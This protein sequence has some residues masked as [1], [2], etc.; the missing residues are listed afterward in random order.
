MAVDFTDVA[1]KDLENEFV[2]GNGIDEPV[3]MYNT[4]AGDPN[5]AIYYYSSDNL[6]SVVTLVDADGDVIERY[7][8]DPWGEPTITDGTGTPLTESA[9][10]NPYMFTAREVDTLDGGSL[11]LQHNRHRVLHYKLARWMQNDP[12]GTVPE[13]YMNPSNPIGQYKDG[14]N[15]YEYVVSSPIDTV[16][17]MGLSP[18]AIALSQ[19][20]QSVPMALGR[21][22]RVCDKYKCPCGDCLSVAQCKRE[23][24]KLYNS[25]RTKL[26][27][28]IKKRNKDLKEGKLP[29]AEK[30]WPWGRCY[31]FCHDY[32]G[33]I[34]S[35]NLGA[36]LKCFKFERAID[37][38]N[39]SGHHYVGVFHICNRSVDTDEPCSDANLDPW[40][41][42]DFF[43]TA[44][45]KSGTCLP[46][47]YWGFEKG[48]GEAFQ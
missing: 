28:F 45:V 15:V 34:S 40:K 9:V 33:E 42:G 43:P 18:T 44:T 29:N 20:G 47:M 35:W 48:I 32:A 27:D 4:T 3:M 16:D 23:A 10:N 24:K 41:G 5:S 30:R 22:Y 37:T 19:L 14:V 1:E 17:E 6:G 46:K 38:I 25:Y 21:L 13:G 12:L 39:H 36:S 11:R 26:N 31:N 7:S 8:Y 2:Y